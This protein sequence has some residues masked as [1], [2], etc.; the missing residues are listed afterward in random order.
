MSDIS[1][2][3]ADKG[4]NAI[5][6]RLMEKVEFRDGLQ[7][8]A[9]GVMIL[10]FAGM[11]GLPMVF[12]GPFSSY[13]SFWGIMLFVL[14]QGFG[15]GQWAIKKVRKRFLPGKVGYVKLKPV[16]RKTVAIRLSIIV[17]LAFIVG[18]LV[19]FVAVKIVIA[20][21]RGG[22]ALHWGLFTPAGWMFVGTGILY[23][24]IMMIRV[25]LLR[26]VI[27]GAM[28]AALSI[29]LAFRGVSLN[30]GLTILYGY[31]GLF[32]IISGSVVFFLTLRQ[33]AEPGE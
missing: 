32:A 23:G 16:S 25:R 11:A 21:I 14:L 20:T 8:I 10:T 7:E 24:A 9:I 33:P 31:A 3:L 30:V 28:M 13:A 18:A 17:G 12:K 6:N 26:Y 22:G 15:G 29:L 1:Q 27:G 4:P 19:S 5:A 2:T